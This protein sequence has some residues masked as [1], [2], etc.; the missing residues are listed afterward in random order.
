MID[1]LDDVSFP[2]PIS[3]RSLHSDKYMERVAKDIPGFLKKYFDFPNDDSEPVHVYNALRHMFQGGRYVFQWATDHGK[4][5]TGTWFFPIMSL[6]ADPDAAHILICANINDARS[7]LQRAARTL[8]SNQA[9]TDDFPWLK[10]PATVGRNKQRGTVWSSTELT[11]SGRTV[12]NRNPSIY[13][14]TTNA[15]DVRGRRG[16]VVMDDIEGT[17]HRIS[18]LER[19]RLMDFVQQ[20]VIT[21]KE[22]P[23]ESSRSLLCAMGT[24]FDVDSIYLKLEGHE[25]DMIKIPAYTV[26]YDQILKYPRRPNGQPSASAEPWEKRASYLKERVFTWPRK[27]YKVTENDPKFGAKMRPADFAI[28]YN[29]DPTVGNPTRL[30]YLQMRK[31]V[32][33]AEFVGEDNWVSVVALDPA[34]GVGEDYAGISVV[35]L[36]WPQKDKLPEVVMLEAHAFEQGLFEQ[37]NFCAELAHQYGTGDPKQPLRLIYESNAQQGG[38]YRNAFGHMRPEIQLVPIYTSQGAKFDTEMGLTVIRELVRE[39]RLK[40]PESQLDAE[41]MQTMLREVRDLGTAAHDHI[42]CSVWFVVRWLYDQVRS[43]N[44]PPL[45]AAGAGSRMG[46][47]AGSIGGGGYVPSW[48]TWRR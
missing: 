40:V 35:R 4:S 7:L 48:R 46:F 9:L 13:A 3:E 1:L 47:G 25:W 41:G 27:R 42:A 16:K 21:C 39:H 44:G 14:T 43:Y 5:Y 38:T 36:R 18:G 26:P 45:V 11:V 37:V 20:E 2:T 8:E 22:D 32:S 17:K 15:G 30:S 6:A 34:A 12:N 28:R 33:S 29:L 31:L 10:K 23:Q 19:R 24:P